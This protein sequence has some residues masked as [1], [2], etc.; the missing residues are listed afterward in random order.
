MIYATNVTANPSIY[1]GRCTAGWLIVLVWF[2]V[3]DMDAQGLPFVQHFSKEVYRGGTQNWDFVQDED[4]ILYV[5]NNEGLGEYDGETWEI[6]PV[7]NRTIVR[8]ATLGATGKVFV[9]AQGECGFFAA[10]E[11]GALTYT[12]FQKELQVLKKK[13]ED[14]WRVVVSADE[15]AWFQSGNQ[16]LKFAN[17]KLRQV[18]VPEGSF[19]YMRRIDSRVIAQD[20][21]RGLVA[22]LPD[23]GQELLVPIASEAIEIVAILHRPNAL[24]LICGRDGEL[25]VWQGNALRPW[26]TEATAYLRQH[27]IYAA[28]ALP[29]G[30]IALGTSQGGVVLLESTGAIRLVLSRRNGLSNN[31]ILSLYCDRQGNLWAGTDN[32]IDCIQVHLPYSFLTPDGELEGT[33]YGAT[34]QKDQA[35]LATSNGLYTAK[36]DKSGT[37]ASSVFSLVPNTQGQTWG[38][39]SLHQEVFVGHHDGP[40]RLTTSGAL[41]LS[42]GVKGAWAFRGVEGNPNLLLCGAYDGLYLFENIGGAWRVRLKYPGLDESC[43]ILAM[44]NDYTLWVAHPYRGLYRFRFNSDYSRADIRFFNAR[45]GLPSDNANSAYSIGGEIVF[46]TE[47]GVYRFDKLKENFEPYDILNQLFS[48]YEQVK[49]LREGYR[50]EIWFV[51]DRDVGFLRPLGSGTGYIRYERVVLPFLRGKLVGGFEFIFPMDAHRILFGSDKGFVFLNQERQHAMPRRVLMRSVYI[52]HPR[53]SLLSIAHRVAAADRGAHLSHRES[54]LQFHFLLP[55]LPVAAGAEY[56]W[57]LI[58][59]DTLWS[60]WSEESTHTFSQLSPGRYRFE[61]E[62][63]TGEGEPV[64]NALYAFRI[65]PPWYFSYGA[66][67]AYT[68]LAALGILLLVALPRRRFEREKE[69]LTIAHQR[70]QEVQEQRVHAVQEELLRVQEAKLQ[71]EIQFKNQELAAT[72]FH[73]LQKSEI[74]HNTSEQLVE[75]GRN[76]VDEQARKAISGVIRELMQPDQLDRD[77]EIFA[78]RFDQVHAHFLRRL[79]E[80]FPQITPK[81]QKLCAYLR[82]NLS[83]KEI[84]P[85]LGISVRSVEVSRYRLRRKLDL[86]SEDNLTEFLLQF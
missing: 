73:L 84:A 50:G 65:S 27:R 59:L 71:D 37:W 21:K 38:V 49:Y 46:S 53:D 2:C 61:V 43:R 35:Y 62:A 47:K 63:R 81:D 1:K 48:S 28:I 74:I 3:G 9:G 76:C 57:R 60:A 8:S 13:P 68:L 23:G 33:A 42:G 40:F 26:R 69:T 58:G 12:S 6:H 41:P 10:D 85:L 86:E 79:K 72:T 14:F 34:F 54:G 16:I 11:R 29:D 56:R 20:S 77:W 67:G 78:Q 17:G 19:T 15:Q 5:A 66:W 31:N 70:V 75:I 80:R 25:F 64:S 32:G 45:N 30:G 39:Y 4:G 82:L 52:T 44:E 7:S 22:L 55:G 24:P 51:A 36:K 83:S 18:W